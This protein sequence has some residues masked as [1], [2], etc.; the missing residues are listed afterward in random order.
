MGLGIR[1]GT[2][3]ATGPNVGRL[4]LGYRFGQGATG[5]RWVVSLGQAYEF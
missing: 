3:G 2:T 1:A 4:D 5:R